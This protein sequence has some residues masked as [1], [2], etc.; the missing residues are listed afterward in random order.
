MRKLLALALLVV[1][2]VSMLYGCGKNDENEKKATK[3]VKPDYSDTYVFGQDRQNNLY[4]QSYTSVCESEDGY[5]YLDKESGFVYVIDKKTHKCQP[6]CN[7]S[8]C[9]HDKE[10]S[11]D[12]KEK[13]NAFF[14][15]DLCEDL[16][17]Y[18][19]NLYYIDCTTVKDDEGEHTVYN[20]YKS[21]LDGTNRDK[22][23]TLNNGNVDSFTV[24]RGFIYYTAEYIGGDCEG[25]AMYKVPVDGN[26][27]DSKVML[28]YYKY[29]DIFVENIMYYGNSI[30]LKI[31][32]TLNDRFYFI[33]YNL[34][35]GKWKDLNK[36]LKTTVTD[37][38]FFNDRIVFADESYTELFDCDLNGENKKKVLDIPKPDKKEDKYYHPYS[39]GTHLIVATAGLSPVD[40]FMYYDDG[41]KLIGEYKMPFAFSPY[42]MCGSNA[43]IVNDEDGNLCYIDMTELSHKDKAECI[44]TFEEE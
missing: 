40:K 34:E 7:K 31:Y 38:V 2:S 17:Y 16:V 42:G 12:K 6:L 28:E 20:F 11:S 9:L 5:Y 1:L 27:D 32:D 43:F 26:V 35:N 44:Y 24:H 13:C 25:M 8:D 10:T 23:M 30:Y 33:K 41:Y 14:G 29:E 4:K 19:N 3:D 22:L 21:S 36:S 37:F 15:Y 39:D 18:M